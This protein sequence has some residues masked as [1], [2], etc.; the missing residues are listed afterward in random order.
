MSI[1]CKL[2]IH[3][4]GRPHGGK[5]GGYVMVCPKCGRTYRAK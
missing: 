3:A 5:S 4:I 1:L 2:G